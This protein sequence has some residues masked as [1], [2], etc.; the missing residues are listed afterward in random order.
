MRTCR[1]CGT[2]VPYSGHG[3][4][5]EYCDTCRQDIKHRPDEQPCPT[6]GWYFEGGGE[7]QRYC[8]DECRNAPTEEDT[9]PSPP[10]VTGTAPWVWE[11]N[12][13]YIVTLKPLRP[14]HTGRTE[15]IRCGI[16]GDFPHHHT[17]HHFAQRQ[18]QIRQQHQPTHDGK[19]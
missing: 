11:V 16:I 5:R 3:R 6:C 1:T 7:W 10:R 19:S 12:E 17:A 13:R 4:P 2:S 9:R 8:S 15:T 18:R 14:K